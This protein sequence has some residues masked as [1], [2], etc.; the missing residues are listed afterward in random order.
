MVFTF[1]QF[2]FISFNLHNRGVTWQHNQ[3]EKRTK[4]PLP[5]TV[6][7]NLNLKKTQTQKLESPHKSDE[8]DRQ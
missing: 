8:K 3:K 4:P 2:Y 7:H 1:C 6:S 5:P